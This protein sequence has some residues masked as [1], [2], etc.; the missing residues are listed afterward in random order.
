MD[1]AGGPHPGLLIVNADDWGYDAP[2]TD[3]TLECFD[4]GTITSATGMV[5]MADSERAAAIAVERGLP[6]GLHVNLNERFTGRD[7][8]EPVRERQ[9][10]VVRWFRRFRLRR[11]VYDPTMRG[12]VD[13]CIADQ[14]GR[15]R[16]LYGREPTHFDGHRHVQVCP[17]VFLSSALPRGATL[18]TTLDLPPLKRSPGA[19]ARSLRQRAIA[20]RFRSTDFFFDIRGVHPSVDPHDRLSLARAATVEVM[21]HPG[22][23]VELEMLGADEWAAALARVRL[24]SYEDMTVAARVASAAR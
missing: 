3:A 18:R 5:W 23:P 17:N 15:F 14:L 16:E 21:A 22:M 24:G 4:A 12:E 7:V 13:R 11:W 6:I 1:G 8:P 19:L 9:A 10:R 2:T 20:A